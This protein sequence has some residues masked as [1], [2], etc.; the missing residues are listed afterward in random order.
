MVTF[1]GLLGHTLLIKVTIS[2]GSCT[3]TS[4]PNTKFGKNSCLGAQNWLH[5]CGCWA[6]TA[7]AVCSHALKHPHSAEKLLSLG[8]GRVRRHF[9]TYMMCITLQLFWAVGQTEAMGMSAAVKEIKQL[10]TADADSS[11]PMTFR[12]CGCYWGG[13]GMSA[14]SWDPIQLLQRSHRLSSQG[15]WRAGRITE[16]KHWQEVPGGGQHRLGGGVTSQTKGHLTQGLSRCMVERE[17]SPF[18]AL[19]SL[20]LPISSC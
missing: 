13:A 12:P 6:W 11:T 7:C 4:W 8:T 5:L 10:S 1:R 15:P 19:C 2:W 9:A 16:V 18:L 20:V 14:R 17:V 3:D